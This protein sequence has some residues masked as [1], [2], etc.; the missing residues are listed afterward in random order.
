MSVNLID[1]PDDILHVIV[2]KTNLLERHILRF[3]S[4]KLHHFVHSISE[5]RL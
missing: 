5:I 3:V 2:Q 1:L 4:K